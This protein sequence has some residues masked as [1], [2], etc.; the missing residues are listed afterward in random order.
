[1]IIRLFKT[2]QY[3][4]IVFLICFQ[5]IVF[6]NAI[7]HAV[8][9]KYATEDTVLYN[10]WFESWSHLKWLNLLLSAILIFSQ[11]L[12]YNYLIVQ[13][14]LLGKTTYLPAFFYVLICC[15][16]PNN[17]LF[18]SGILSTSFIVPAIYLLLTSIDDK[19][20]L[21]TVFNTSLLF[22]IGSLFYLHALFY[23]PFVLISLTIL[24]L[25][26]FR[27]LVVVII[28]FLIPYVYI[29]TYYFVIDRLDYYIQHQF[30]ELISFLPQKIS[31]HNSE[32]GIYILLFIILMISLFKF[33]KNRFTM[34]VLHRKIYYVFTWFFVFTIIIPLFFSE[35]HKQQFFILA[36]PMGVFLSY[37]FLEVRR[38]WIADTAIVLFFIA[39]AVLQFE[40]YY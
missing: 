28:G 11:A 30:I 13:L 12:I 38:Q 4:G 14:N 32:I 10:L 7:L 9:N 37:Y 39:I 22:S 26:N 29:F 25:L 33:I 19:N 1:M 21:K 8:P 18:N 15:M 35:L 16:L 24:G 31:L 17:L 36:I 2:N 20:P 5:I 23:L 34:K 40:F 6:V 3:S 27:S